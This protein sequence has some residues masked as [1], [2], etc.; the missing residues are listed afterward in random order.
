MRLPCAVS[1]A[2]CFVGGSVAVD[3]LRLIWFYLANLAWLVPLRSMAQSFWRL[4]STLYSAFVLFRSIGIH[5]GRLCL[6]DS[7]PKACHWR[8]VVYRR[9][10]SSAY[11]DIHVYIHRKLQRSQVRTCQ[12]LVEVCTPVFGACGPHRLSFEFSMDQ[13]SGLPSFKDLIWSKH[14]WKFTKVTYVP[15]VEDRIGETGGT[16]IRILMRPINTPRTL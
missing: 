9:W 4:T 2:L 12:T 8:L 13:L 1:L 7:V 10:N 15:Q 16:S 14:V 6:L 11:E 5:G 3:L